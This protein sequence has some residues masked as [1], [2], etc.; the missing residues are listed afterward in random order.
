MEPL[1]E[2]RITKAIVAQESGTSGRIAVRVVP[3]VPSDPVAEAH[4]QLHAAG[5]HDLDDRNAIVFLVAPKA[6]RF[7]VYG[8]RSIH[9]RVGAAFWSDVVA[10]MTPFFKEGD[11]TA[12]LLRGIERAGSALRKHFPMEESR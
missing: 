2:D 7:A 11:P 12:G 5:L 8:D 3:H 10:E 1:D 6:R 4:A 9:K